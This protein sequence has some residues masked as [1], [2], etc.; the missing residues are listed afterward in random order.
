MTRLA[1]DGGSPV[2]ASLLPYGHQWLDEEDISA[3]VEVLRSDWLTTGPKVTEF[4]Q[5]FAERVG[6]REAVAVS[7]GTAALHAAMYALDIRPGDEVI[8]PPMTFAA[9]ANCV[10]F[11]GGTPV[12]AD[13]DPDTLL[14]DPAQVE[15]K[16]TPHTRA[17]IAVDYTGQPCDYDALRTLTDKYGLYLVADACHALGG[18]Y[19]GRPVGSL[20]DL[21]TFSF[22]PVK[23]ITTGEGGMIT[24]D[25][26]EMAR[27]MR[28]FSNHGITADHRQREKQGS[29]F[30][31][32]VDLGYNYRLTDLQCALGMAQ[33]RKLQEWVARRR[34]IAQHYDVAFGEIPAVQPLTVREEV[35][36]AY[37]LYVIRL[38]TSKLQATRAEL[39]A[40]LRAEAIGINVHY[41]PVHLHP[42][43]RERFST[44]PGMCPVAEAA[45]EE[46]ISLPIFP[47][48][49]DNDIND[50]VVAVRKVI[51]RYQ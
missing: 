51:H 28:I 10:V 5:V 30:Y 41:I 3:V 45:Y 2:R 9:T 17:V 27:R 23:H 21:S 50:A 7:N 36:H 1:I 47:R 13:V 46:I 35:S 12:F 18:S 43:Y 44:E 38:D 37:H 31:E 25:D 24:T 39:F 11:Q 19:K 6:A 40:A 8:L 22:H 15:S 16:I 14:L 33:L 26:P 42:F 4:E 34:E 20:A 29:W 48:M 32:M 49:S